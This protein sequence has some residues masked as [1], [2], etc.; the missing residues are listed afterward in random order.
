[1]ILQSDKLGE[2]EIEQDKI[3]TFPQG[4]PGFPEDRDYVIIPAGTD[5]NPFYFL[6]STSDAE[7]CFI[8][9]EPHSFYS[10]YDFELS[11][12]I[13]QQLAIEQ[14]EDVL[15]YSLVTLKDELKQATTN[16]QAPVVINVKNKKAR[17]FIMN[18]TKFHTRTPLFPQEVIAAQQVAAD[19]G[20]GEAREG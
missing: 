1:M 11:E 14:P 2:I 9:T 13:V 12:E 20:T 15:I 8:M 3:I 10:D 7:L 6:Q 19:S 5:D 16:L 18:D 4:I 17:Q